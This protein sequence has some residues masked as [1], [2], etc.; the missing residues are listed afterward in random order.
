[1]DAIAR[2]RFRPGTKNGIAVPVAATV[3]VNFRLK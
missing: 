2:W 3:E 1:M